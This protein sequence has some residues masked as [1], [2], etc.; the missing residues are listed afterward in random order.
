MH[1]AIAGVRSSA[2]VVTMWTTCKTSEPVESDV[3]ALRR[4]RQGA[5]ADA[6]N[7]RLR[8]GGN[9]FQGHTPRSFQLNL[10]E[11]VVAAC[12]CCC[13]IGERHI[14]QKHNVWLLGEHLIRTARVCRPRSRR[15]SVAAAAGGARLATTCRQRSMAWAGE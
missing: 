9:R 11:A 1:E 15:E 4:M 12:Y 7:A 3:Q 5:N 2:A 10:R 13:E 8:N 6:I 14:V